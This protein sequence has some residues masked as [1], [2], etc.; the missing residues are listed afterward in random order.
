[1]TDNIAK[2]LKEFTLEDIEKLKLLS[3]IFGDKQIQKPIQNVT[4]EHGLNECEKLAEFNQEAKTVS[5]MKTAN[6]R[7]LKVIPGNRFITELTRKEAE[8][9]FKENSKTAPRGAYNYHKIYHTEFNQFKKLGY[10][11]QNPFDINLPKLQEEEPIVISDEEI[12]IICDKLIEM[13]KPVISDMVEFA[14]L[15]ALRLSEETFL[16]WSDVDLRNRIMTIGNR[17]LKTKSKR[18]RKIP[19]NERM[20]NILRRNSER[21]LTNGKMLREFVFTQ[22]SGKHFK[23][24]TI[25]KSFKKAV[26]A[27]GL[28]ELYHW[29]CLRAT[30]ASNWVNKKVP[31]YTVQ[32]LLG[33]AK[34]STTSQYYAKVNIDELRDAV[35]TL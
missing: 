6:R 4:I 34:T 22:N 31:I 32:K 5:L 13:Q 23:T 24:D 29:H 26:R 3:Q 8:Y 25:S 28:S 30:A 33:H 12:K 35:N 20:E 14:T 11:D 17:L 2:I 15:S 16:R 19:L 1:M 10:I 18:Y 9:I 7:F 27:A 21:Q